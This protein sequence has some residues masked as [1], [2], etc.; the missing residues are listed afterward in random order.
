MLFYHTKDKAHSQ[1][2]SIANAWDVK[3]KNDCGID[4]LGC[5]SISKSP[6][7]HLGGFRLS[8]VSNTVVYETIKKGKKRCPHFFEGLFA[9]TTAAI[10]TPATTIRSVAHRLKEDASAG[11]SVPSAVVKFHV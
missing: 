1:I 5:K 10:P 6:C 3:I 8:T 4:R 2:S 11:F 7:Q 9:R